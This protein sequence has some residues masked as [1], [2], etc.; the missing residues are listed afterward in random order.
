M[1]LVRFLAAIAFVAV[2]TFGAFVWVVAPD[3]G[4][5]WSPFAVAA[6]VVFVIGGG[7]TIIEPSSWSDK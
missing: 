3:M 5:W 2:C 6:F 4:P 7:I 1:R